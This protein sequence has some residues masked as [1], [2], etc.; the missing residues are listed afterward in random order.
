[1][2]VIDRNQLVEQRTLILWGIVLV[3][4]GVYAPWSRLDPA[5]EGPV[6]DIGVYGTTAGIGSF[7]LGLLLPALGLLAVVLVVEI[8]HRWAI[9][10]A[11]V[12]ILYLSLP[13]VHAWLLNDQYILWIGAVLTA[14]G[15][16]LIA[17][18]ATWSLFD[19]AGSTQSD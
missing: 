7:E 5:H 16:L 18:T 1:V 13:G 10:I 2:V 15:G 12:G 4:G 3:I 11:V 8:T 17:L 6:E 19:P 14:L 9:L